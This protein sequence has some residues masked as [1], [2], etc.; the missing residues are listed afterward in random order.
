MKKRR[1]YPKELKARVAL[2]ALKGEKTIAEISSEYEVG[3]NLVGGR[4]AYYITLHRLA[5]YRPMRSQCSAYLCRRRNDA[6]TY[7]RRGYRKSLC[8]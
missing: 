5:F 4:S 8:S 1:K 6:G 2:E 7:L 3:P